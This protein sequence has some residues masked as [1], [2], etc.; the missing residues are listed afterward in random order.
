MCFCTFSLLLLLILMISLF[1]V[2]YC[3]VYNLLIRLR[4]PLKLLS[5]SCF[6][7][8]V[9]TVRSGR[10]FEGY[11]QSFSKVYFQWVY[12]S[13]EV[14]E[15]IIEKGKQL[16]RQNTVPR[17]TQLSRRDGSNQRVSRGERG[18]IQK[19]WLSEENGLFQESLR[20]RDA[21][22]DEVSKRM[23]EL[24]LKGQTML[25][26]YCPTCSG[27]LME[28]RAGVRRCVTC[29]LY[30]EKL[31]QA[32]T[33]VAE[34]PLREFCQTQSEFSFELKKETNLAKLSTTSQ[35]QVQLRRKYRRKLL[36]L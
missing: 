9:A 34:V 13:Q 21:F 5:F 23:G 8:E 11:L 32:G 2:S 25:D 10:Y 18:R 19:G 22:R 1:H 6:L 14:C 26:E 24:L 28:D 29:E 31:A 3:K 12:G 27:I 30:A 33:I 35:G 16:D 20:L 36:L 17:S 7:I 4:L 15:H